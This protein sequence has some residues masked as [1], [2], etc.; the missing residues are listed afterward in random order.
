MVWSLKGCVDSRAEQEAE[1]SACGERS[2]MRREDAVSLLVF[3]HVDEIEIKD[4][5]YDSYFISVK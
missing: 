5:K 1:G 4:V 2:P 3:E